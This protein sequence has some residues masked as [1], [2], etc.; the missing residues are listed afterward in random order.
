MAAPVISEEQWQLAHHDLEAVL[1]RARQEGQ[2]SELPSSCSLCS[3]LVR[4]VR[5]P[6]PRSIEM[7]LD[8]NN[9]HNNC[10]SHAVVLP[11]QKVATDYKILLKKSADHPF[12]FLYHDSATYESS[13][14][15]TETS[16]SFGVPWEPLLLKEP[17]L[18]QHPA[19]R[20]LIFPRLIDREW[21]DIKLLKEWYSTCVNSHAH[22][23]GSGEPEIDQSFPKLL[24]IDTQRK[25]LVQMERS[26]R[27]IALSYCWGST[28]FFLTTT[29]NMGQLFQ[30]QAFE[31]NKLPKTIKQAIAL[32]SALGEQYLWVDSLCIVQN[33][34]DKIDHLNAM[35]SLYANS[36]LTIVAGEDDHADAGFRG[37]NGISEPRLAKQ[38]IATLSPSEILVRPSSKHIWDDSLLRPWSSRAWTFQEAIFPHRTLYFANNT[39]RWCCRA[40]RWSE[41]S[42]SSHCIETYSGV[43]RIQH[44]PLSLRLEAHKL[45]VLGEYEALVNSYNTRV[46]TYAEDVL[47]AFA[48]VAT[49]L[50]E[51]FDG[52]LISGLPEMFFDMC[53]LW[54][55]LR[56]TSNAS[57]RRP[58]RLDNGPVYLPSWSWAGWETKVSWPYTWNF[59]E[60]FA[61]PMPIM[62]KKVQPFFRIQLSYTTAD[63]TTIPVR[64][65]WLDKAIEI[66]GQKSL[67]G[68]ETHAIEE[69]ASQEWA[70]SSKEVIFENVSEPKNDIRFC[71]PIQLST[72]MVPARNTNLL[73]FRTTSGHFKLGEIRSSA[74]R[75]HTM[76]DRPAGTLWQNDDNDLE[77]GISIELIAILGCTTPRE[78]DF[79][80]EIPD[81]STLTDFNNLI[82]LPRT[83]DIYNVMWIIRD[84]N[85]IAFRKGTG[86]IL[87]E[88]W[89]QEAV[90]WIDVRLG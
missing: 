3:A 87:R 38:Q 57:R 53:L 21:I 48:G 7:Q 30:P 39:V 23:C 45:P 60:D 37:L 47:F 77:E 6:H 74:A 1:K 22:T 49:R 70:L 41:E 27:Y 62:L 31:H 8:I 40:R 9:E 65:H 19:R 58:K 71:F 2:D 16:S 18:I 14:R 82:K 20:P 36:T 81:I 72:S 15:S 42:H 63:G 17:Q 75:I 67:P 26:C 33:G 28:N 68:W 59:T 44:R 56:E 85:D 11:P 50:A 43:E 55:P 86:I 69:Y 89:E 32:T 78:S 35:A 12:V 4:L 5:A 73:T 79:M 66:M 51:K 52:G 83:E 76:N 61:G 54:R 13:S 46:F 24:L 80:W 84:D 88:V 34:P 90:D 25:C 29:E 64:A 10:Q